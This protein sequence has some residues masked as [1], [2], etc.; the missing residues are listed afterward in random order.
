MTTKNLTKYSFLL[1]ICIITGLKALF[2]K[3]TP[4]FGDEALYCFLGLKFLNTPLASAWK[5]GTIFWK[6]AP[7]LLLLNALSLKLFGQMNPIFACRMTSVICSGF[8]AIVFYRIAIFISKNKK[9][10]LIATILLLLNPFSFFFDR[11][12]LMDAPLVTFILLF[13]YFSLRFLKSGKWRYFIGTILALILMF[14]TKF[15]S[16]L[17]LP[18]TFYLMYGQDFNTAYKK[19]YLFSV[20]IITGILIFYTAATTKIWETVFYHVDSSLALEDLFTRT[21]RNIKLIMSWLAQFLS[22]PILGLFFWGFLEGIKRQKTNIV[23]ISPFFFLIYAVTSLTLFARYLLFILPFFFLTISFVES[24]RIGKLLLYGLLIYF[25]WND[26]LILISPEKAALAKE[27][28]FEFFQDW[29][30]GIGTQILFKQLLNFSGISS[31]LIIPIDLLGLVSISNIAYAPNYK[32]ETITVSNSTEL[33]Q[34]LK[35]KE[36]YLIITTIQH[37]WMNKPLSLY[38]NTKLLFT[39]NS[40]QRNAVLLYEKSGNHETNN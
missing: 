14:M 7:G 16:L 9:A 24:R 35:N 10:S 4:L 30:S 5:Y 29:G 6:D 38:K 18:Y 1:F 36:Q 8:S 33:E 26:S 20:F 27:V 11:T 3:R 12:S 13:L 31:K 34:L 22:L 23:L 32:I 2:L 17:I 19:K 28:K 21:E 37:E 39:T 40:R 15:N 25:I